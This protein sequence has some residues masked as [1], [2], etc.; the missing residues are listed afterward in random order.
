M[1]LPPNQVYSAFSFVGFLMCAIPFYWHLES[2]NTGTCLYMAWTGLG[3]LI[4]CI[5]SIVWNK[6]MINRAPVYCD[7]ATRIQVAMNVAIP[8]ASLCINHRLYKMVANVKPVGPTRA[9]K[10]RAIITDLL[11]G[12][13]I[14][15][16]QIPAQYVVSG[17]RYNIYED[18]GPSFEIVF[19]PPSFFLFFAWPVAIGCVSLVY[20]VLSIYNFKEV[21]TFNGGLNRGRYLRLIALSSVEILGTIPL[22]TYFIVSNAKMGVTPWISWDDTHSNY[23]RVVQIAAFIWKSDPATV[24]SIELYRWLLVLCAFIFF[25]F[26]GFAVEARR[27]YRLAFTSLASCIGLLTTSFGTL[28]GSSHATSSLPH[29]KS[30]GGIT[31]SVITATGERRDSTVSFTDQLSIPSISLASDLKPDF[32]IEQYSLSDSMV[33]SSM[34]SFEPMASG[35]SPELEATTPAVDPRSDQ[36]H[37]PDTTKSI[38]HVYSSDVADTV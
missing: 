20:C 13:G 1:A 4:Q 32:N 19:M 5:N 17:H 25:A 9:E 34:D 37:P 21:I 23:S 31:V 35:Q 26:F 38:L 36:P 12:L 30:K 14:P 11:I 2:W 6:N 29:V 18:F 22:G 27:H 28:H 3:C 8:A 10:R 16:L 15:L 24:V 7:I 33:S